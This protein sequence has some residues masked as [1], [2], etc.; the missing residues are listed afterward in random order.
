MSSPFFP[1]SPP[2]PPLALQNAARESD[3][4]LQRGI[5]AANAQNGLVSIEDGRAIRQAFYDTSGSVE[6]SVSQLIGRK[7]ELQRLNAVKTTHDGLV[8][9]S[10]LN[11]AF[12]GAVIPK[13][14]IKLRQGIRDAQGRIGAAQAKGLAAFS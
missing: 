12:A 2:I 11:R 6:S 5:N 4:A 14:G 13:V 10:G 9:T 3:E 1:F 8:K 7:A